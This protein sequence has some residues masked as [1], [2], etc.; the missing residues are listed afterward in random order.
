MT[1]FLEWISFDELP[2][3]VVL[4]CLLWVIG[5]QMTRP[6]EF[7]RRWQRRTAAAV[8]FAYVGLASYSWEPSGVSDL[9]AIVIRATLAAAFVAGLASI[10]LP[11]AQGA[12]LEIRS[13]MK[14]NHRDHA[15][16]AR[17]RLEQERAEREAKARERREADE[18]TRHAA[19]ME[20]LRKTAAV[21]AARADRERHTTTDEARASVISFYDEHPALPAELLPR[22][23][24]LAQLQTRFPEKVTPEQAWKAAE[25]MISAM[26]P[27][28]AQA[29]ER[30]QRETEEGRE[31]QRQEEQRTRL[32]SLTAWYD[33]QR[34][35]IER[36]L[37]E[38]RERDDIVSQ[39]WD[40]YD[41]LVK[42][43]LKELRP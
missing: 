43:T 34:R 36:Q 2:E 10:V 30:Q 6:T 22:A 18:R 37:P 20:I 4:I 1:P 12:A 41:E 17:Q 33:E 39:L 26:Q 28:I 38:G 21:A 3:L 29:K 27:L 13:A 14:T 40:R 19:Q 23:L 5:G 24:F 8:L 42:Q 35:E 11:L 25:E 16:E 15:A 31:R 7:S 32:S 9:L